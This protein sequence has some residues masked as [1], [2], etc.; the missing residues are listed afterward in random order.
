MSGGRTSEH[1]TMSKRSC[2]MVI[3]KLKDHLTKM[4]DGLKDEK[5]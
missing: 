1:L 2:L 3:L 5:S 4:L